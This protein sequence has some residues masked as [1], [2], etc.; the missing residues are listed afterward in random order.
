MSD[1]N[2]PYYLLRKAILNTQRLLLA[3]PNTIVSGTLSVSNAVAEKLQE[4]G[5]A[6]KGGG[7]NNSTD[8]VEINQKHFAKFQELRKSK[9]HRPKY[10][11]LVLVMSFYN[12]LPPDRQNKLLALYFSKF[13]A[14]SKN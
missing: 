12:K 13:T 2:S 3:I 8:F 9:D 14:S 10:D 1:T 6:Y 5:D 11:E 7:D 4:L